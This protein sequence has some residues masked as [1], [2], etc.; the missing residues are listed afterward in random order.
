MTIR[1]NSLVVG[2]AVLSG[3]GGDQGPSGPPSDDP[4]DYAVDTSVE[5]DLEV[6]EP[7]WVVPSDALPPEIET[8]D[9]NNNVAIALHEDRLFLAWR[10]AEYHFASRNAK[11]FIVSSTDMG[12]SWDFEQEIAL[13]TDLREPFL[14]VA[15][16]V[17]YL[18]FFEAGDLPVAFEPHVMWRTAR[19]GL[20][21]WTDLETWGE[22]GEI[23]WEIKERGGRVYLTSY[24]G[25][26]Y[27]TGESNVDVRFWVSDDGVSWAAI[28][29]DDPTVYHGGCSEAGFEFDAEGALWAVL[30]NEDGDETG[31]GSLLCHAEPDA[32]GQWDCPT[33]SDPE[34]YDSPRMFRH[35]DDLYLVARRDID[36]PYDQGV[37]GVSYVELRGQYLADYS[38]RPKR[39]AIYRIDRAAERVVHIVDLP[40]AGDTAFPS[41]RRLGPHQ[42]LVANYTSPLDDPDISWV[43][44]QA[45]SEGTQ[46]YL[47]TL[48]FVARP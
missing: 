3:C 35:G 44:G 42:V 36:G 32:L 25:D 12:E 39:T 15:R 6:S 16:D 4:D 33:E 48:T 23:P 29:A 34:R 30:R 47:V 20:G 43:D 21:E 11:I 26:H 2:L 41:I 1:W 18:T 31:F 7:R 24:L 5:Y 13:R 40:S 8:M 38:A 28:D 10:T 46:I 9:S 19:Q 17:L 27:G 14:Y 37:E 22:P 45:S